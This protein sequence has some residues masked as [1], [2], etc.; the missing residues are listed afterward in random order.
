MSAGLIE[1][2][3]GPCVILTPH[4]FLRHQFGWACL[5]ALDKRAIDASSFHAT[6]PAACCRYWKAE[7][8]GARTQ[9]QHACLGML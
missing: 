1:V 3:L 2:D 8:A 9:L 4:I 7:V 5:A 6:E